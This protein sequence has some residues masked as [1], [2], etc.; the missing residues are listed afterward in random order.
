MNKRFLLIATA[1]AALIACYGTVEAR[2]GGQVILP[3]TLDQLLPAGS[4][5]LVSSTN[6]TDRFDNFT[7]S[8]SPSNA[9]PQADGVSVSEFH[10]GIEAGLT[11]GGAFFALPGQILDYR[12][13]FTV[14]A[15]PGHLI[16]D[17]LLSGVFNVPSGAQGFTV[18][19]GETITEHGTGKVLAQFSID[20]DNNTG[21]P[22]SW[23]GVQ[24]ID[25]QK[26]ILVVGGTGTTGAGISIINQGF[27][28][29]GVPEP[30]SLALLGIG[31]TGF[32]AFRRF[33]KKTSVA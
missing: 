11:F 9:V 30:A 26:D 24:A 7:Y 28:S 5:A 13:G 1:F 20:P 12:I 18:H 29:T 8:T 2:A 6:E 31:M 3:T 23:A 22:V 4:F 16:N 25:V 21:I 17:A 32:L 27:S 15:A 10:A 14:T 19:V 33:F